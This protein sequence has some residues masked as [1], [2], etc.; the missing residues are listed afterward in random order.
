MIKTELNIVKFIKNG[1]KT[2]LVCKS[3]DGFTGSTVFIDIK[4]IEE[5]PKKIIIET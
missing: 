4:N 2:S 1:N 3:N 5:I